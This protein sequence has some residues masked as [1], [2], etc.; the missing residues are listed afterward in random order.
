M[1]YQ[2]DSDITF[3]YGVLKTKPMIENCNFSEIFRRKTKL[4]AWLVSKCNVPSLRDKFVNKF[5]Q[6][7]LLHGVGISF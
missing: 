1:S 2:L 4:S 6:Y 5:K 7:G 3:P